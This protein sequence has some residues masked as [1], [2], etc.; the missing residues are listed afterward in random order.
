[1]LRNGWYILDENHVPVPVSG[2]LEWAAW[3]EEDDNRRNLVQEQVGESLVST[4]FLGWD[5]KGRFS[6]GPPILF[7]TMILEGEHHGWQRRCSTFGEAQALHGRA[8]RLVRTGS[9]EPLQ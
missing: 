8:V 7:E 6:A 2:L 4:I 5:H 1:M 9:E 3:V